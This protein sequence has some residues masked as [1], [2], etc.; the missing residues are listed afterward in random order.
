MEFVA[1]PVCEFHLKNIALELSLYVCSWSK[2]LKLI[3]MQLLTCQLAVI[4]Y[5]N[6]A[7][8]S[9][10]AQLDTEAFILRSLSLHFISRV[11]VSINFA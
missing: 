7:F 10:E 8:L 3:K 6:Q 5:I 11:S 9:I 2:G 4:F 1:R